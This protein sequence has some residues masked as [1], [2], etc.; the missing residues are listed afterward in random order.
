MWNQKS[1]SSQL[2][3]MLKILV[4]LKGKMGLVQLDEQVWPAR[5]FPNCLIVALGKT[6]LVIN[7]GISRRSVSLEDKL[8]L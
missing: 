2:L 4:C 3:W 7:S 6:V 1:S 8:N 5:D